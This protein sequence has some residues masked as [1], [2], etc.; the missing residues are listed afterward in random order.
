MNPGGDSTLRKDLECWIRGETFQE[1]EAILGAVE[2]SFPSEEHPAEAEILQ[3]DIYDVDDALNYTEKTEEYE[4]ETE[5]T[6]VV[7]E[8]IPVE[9]IPE[10]REPV[11]EYGHDKN[12]DY[13]EYY[14]KDEKQ[15]KWE[16][17]EE[18][19]SRLAMRLRN[20]KDMRR[21]SPMY[22][23]G[24]LRKSRGRFFTLCIVVVIIV[25][26]ATALY[27]NVRRNSFDMMMDKA[28]GLYAQ[29]QYAASYEAYGEASLEYPERVEP[30]LGKAH[31]AERMGR[32]DDAITAYRSSLE[33][34]P[35]D[36]AHSRSS[37]FYEIGRLYSTLK[38]WDKAQESFE[39]AIVAD[40]AN[41]GAYFSLGN[42]LEEQ[43]QPDRALAAYKRALELSPSSDAA[44]EAVRRTSLVLSAREEKERHEI[45]ERGYAQAVLSG[46]VALGGKRYD[47]ASRYFSEAL[48]VRSNDAVAWTGFA[49]AR[50]RLGDT[51]GAIKSL[52]RALERDPDH[53]PAKSKLAEIEAQ[54]RR[55]RQR[56]NTRSSPR[57]SISREALFG[58]GVELY[59]KGDYAASFSSFIA[60]LRSPGKDILPSAPLAGVHGPMWKGYQV[61]LN[62]PSDARL[63]ADAVRLNPMDRDLYVNLSMAGIKMGMDRETMRSTLKEAHSHAL[64]RASNR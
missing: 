39:K 47:E 57:S 20:I 38:A 13:K 41:Y 40:A 46:D 22:K 16:I 7:A 31:S 21:A 59:H 45:A 61:R 44:G 49:E 23:R 35:S 11:D 64:L 30:L 15:P 3:D 10:G 18:A 14:R 24:G 33:H 62:V 42:S 28:R 34:F 19:G 1:T 8:N 48:A 50:F 29:E 6:E 37:A 54:T 60:C 2:S 27:R 36:A 51:A 53:E 32:A 25:C 55:P 63:L 12:E 56:R 52:E 58:E 26:T 17:L 9:D 5:E 4:R 43:D